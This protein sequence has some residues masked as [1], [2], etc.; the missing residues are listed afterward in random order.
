MINKI[1]DTLIVIVAGLIVIVVSGIAVMET[2]EAEDW[3]ICL[4]RGGWVIVTHE[5]G[6]DRSWCDYG[7]D[8]RAVGWYE[9][10]TPNSW[11]HLVPIA[12]PVWQH[13]PGPAG[14]PCDPEYYDCT[15]QR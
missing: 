2:T 15:A 3:I 11:I 5:D 14:I 8:G 13:D 1:I 4:G 7:E 12:N 10:G 9:D 6:R